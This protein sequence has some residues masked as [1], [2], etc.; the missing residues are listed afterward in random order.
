[1]S[2]GRRL[3]WYPKALDHQR[4]FECLRLQM[5]PV[6]PNPQ[7]EI[8]GIRARWTLNQRSAE[9]FRSWGLGV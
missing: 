3:K 4:V 7:F 6:V 1:M 5:I 8:P 9:V 2:D